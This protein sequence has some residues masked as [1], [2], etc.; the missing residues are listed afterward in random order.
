MLRRFLFLHLAV[1]ALVCT[2]GLPSRSNAQHGRGTSFGRSYRPSYSENSFG[3]FNHNFSAAQF[4]RGL[5]GFFRRSAGNR[6]RS[7]SSESKYYVGL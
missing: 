2:I 6:R 5:G 3:N 1:L 7:G 4:S